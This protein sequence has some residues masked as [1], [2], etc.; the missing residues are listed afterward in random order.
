MRLFIK[1]LVITLLIIFM[2]QVSVAAEV[3][4]RLKGEIVAVNSQQGS[5]LFK[6]SGDL[7]EYQVNLHTKLSLNGS[8]VNL[9]A[10]RPVTEEDFQPAVIKLNNQGNLIEVRAEYDALPIE[11]RSVSKDKAN[12][13]VNILNSN[14]VLDITYQEEIILIR[15]GSQIEID[16]LQPGDQGLVILGLEDKVR[17]IKVKNYQYRGE[18]E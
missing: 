4:Q 15:N 13:K 14:K 3:Q 2:F 11:I 12:L 5:F 9:K 18:A 6:S 7:K 17:K 10:L 16:E 1:L 8:Q